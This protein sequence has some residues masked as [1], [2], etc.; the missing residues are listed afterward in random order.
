[1]DED[2]SSPGWT[3]RAACRW[4]TYS[5]LWSIA[6]GAA[7]CSA[8]HPVLRIIAG[9]FG[10]I[11]A[12]SLPVLFATL[13]E[14]V[15]IRQSR[16]DIP[17]ICFPWLGSVVVALG[18]LSL[19]QASSFLVNIA[20]SAR[21]DSVQALSQRF[22]GKDPKQLPRSVCIKK[23]FVKTE[24]EAGKLQCEGLSGHVHCTKAFVAAP[25]FDTK[26]LSDAGL[27][28]E[29]YA[30]AVT[31]GRHVDANYR[32]DGTLC[33]YL[34][35][36]MELDYHI[37]DYRL[38]VT[39]VIQK[40]NLKLGQFAGIPQDGTSAQANGTAG[41]PL[42]A[43]PLLLTSDPLEVTHIEQAW[44]SLGLVLLCCCP[45]AGPTPVGIFLLFACWARRGHYGPVSP[46]D[47]DEEGLQADSKPRFGVPGARSASQRTATSG[48]PGAGQR[49]GV[50]R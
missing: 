4:V 37:S 45:C 16:Y 15:H 33:G 2:A 6:V 10:C 43:R 23:A 13:F 8:Y 17:I 47:Y 27:S 32:R 11:L 48:I 30:W 46:N 3:G 26:V 35:G 34:N 49:G 38:A 50:Y 24:W 40:H 39:R 25:V 42:E 18:I 36:R 31:A 1:M 44:L 29:I 14:M 21:V 22:A 41:S 5:L 7:L 28:E 9:L 12:I 20:M 19:L